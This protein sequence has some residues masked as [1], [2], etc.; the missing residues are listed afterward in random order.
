VDLG[1]VK[2][3]FVRI[4]AG[5]FRMGSPSS[6]KDRSSEE[7]LH[8]VVITRD[9]YL[10]KYPVTRGQF[11]VFV[12]AANY[13]TE[14]E[15][16]DGGNGWDPLKKE[17][18][19]GRE[20]NWRN[21][22]FAQTDNHP[23]VEVGWQDAVMFCAW[24]GRQAGRKMRLPTE[25]EWEY[26]CRAGTQTA[27]HFGDDPRELS[28]YSWYSANSK[29]GTHPVGTK[30]PNAWGLYDMHGNVSQWCQDWHET[31]YYAQSPK[32]DPQG[33][34]DGALRSVRGG[35]WYSTAWFCRS[36]HRHFRGP[37]YCE[38]GVGFRVAFRLD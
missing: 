6:E 11:R 17:K 22:G 9:F 2:M 37:S 24:A 14:A 30:K 27:Y 33:P 4:P 10:G 35:A 16:G 36:A 38:E 20:F 23:V 34:N 26:A 12:Q 29:E 1:G 7:E 21:P 31:T 28:E 8:E 15:L 19:Q 13:K 32:R 25:A 18:R 5:M 3:E